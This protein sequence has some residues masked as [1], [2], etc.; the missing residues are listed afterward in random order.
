M[1][2]HYIEIQNKNAGCHLG[3]TVGLI[4]ILRQFSNERLNNRINIKGLKDKASLKLLWWLS[5]QSIIGKG[6]LTS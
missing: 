1:S 4:E 2:S 5:S 6:E 3:D